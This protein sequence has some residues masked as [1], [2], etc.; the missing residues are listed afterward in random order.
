MAIVRL[1]DIFVP[2]V[3]NP[4]VSVNTTEK[5]ALYQT[6]VISPNADMQGKLGG[7][8][9]IFQTPFWKDLDNDEAVIVTD[10]PE[11]EIVPKKL[12]TAK[13]QFV[14]QIRAQS[15]STADLVKYLAGA[16]PML[17][18]GERVSA[19]W[20]RQI[21]RT[22][23]ATIKGIIADNV[24]NDSGDMVN[25]VTGDSGTVTD[26]GVTANAYQI[27]ASAV[28]DACYTM[29]DNAEGLKMMIM[30]SV[31]YSR[32]L[33]QDLIS[34][35]PNSEGKLVIP[36]YL[37]KQVM[38]SD[39]CPADD[40]GGGNIFYTTYLCGAGV[41]GW[42]E[43]PVDVPSEVERKPSKGNGMGIEIL[44]NRMQYALH[45]GGFSWLDASCAD[46][47]PTNTELAL[48][49]NWNRVFPE[50]KQIQLAVLKTKN[51]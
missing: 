21:D 3:F 39:M 51:G 35:V 11:D 44:H 40:Q 27:H 36:T 37:G 19:Y 1:S 13:H 10:D 7:G 18:I 33:K 4:Y 47:F 8:G 17:R 49:A 46:D 2:D 43:S 6:G 31:P 14:R 22:G 24:A 25:D 50:R 12:T 32:L 45:P 23:I 41:L 15:W 48:A 28:I 29:G 26:G 30:H 9:R 34:F 5:S 42:A 38:V 20:G 16:D